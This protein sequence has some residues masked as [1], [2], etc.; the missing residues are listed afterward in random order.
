MITLYD[1]QSQ[2]FTIPA[3]PYDYSALTSAIDEETMKIHHQKHHQGYVD[4]LNAALKDGNIEHHGDLAALLKKLDTLPEGVRT[5]VQNNGG[6]H[7]NHSL[8]WQS[9]GP[10]QGEVSSEFDAAIK[11]DL[12]G[13]D[14]FKESFAGAALKQFGSGWAW[15]AIHDGTLTI[16]GTPN[17]DNPL[18]R[19]D[20][21]I[22]GLDVWEHAYYLRYQNKRPDYVAAWWDVVN[23]SAVSEY[24]SSVIS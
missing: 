3:L 16:Y 14:A 2:Q 18:M 8:F 17:Q 19:G 4:K 6:G 20:T 23:W 9:M 13:I 5:A 15:L 24:Y 7:Y 10:N 12:G 11:K 21:P 1:K 22:L